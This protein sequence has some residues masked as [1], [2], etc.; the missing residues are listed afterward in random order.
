MGKQFSKDILKK[1]LPRL[2]RKDVEDVLAAVGRGELFSADVIKAVYLD[3]QERV[4]QKSSFK[5]GEEGW[6]NIE[7][8]Q[9]MILRFQKM[10]RMR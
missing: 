3:Y 5:P 7:N 1:V 2:A 9:G 4:V 8:A 10:K 6:F